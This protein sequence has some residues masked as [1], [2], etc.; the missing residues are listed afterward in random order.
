[1]FVSFLPI[2]C[3]INTS[4]DLIAWELSSTNVT[5]QHS[6]CIQWHIPLPIQQLKNFQ[7]NQEHLLL[8]NVSPS[9]ILAWDQNALHCLC[10]IHSLQHKINLNYS[11]LFKL[12]VHILTSTWNT[13][14]NCF[15]WY[16]HVKLELKTFAYLSFHQGW[17]H[18]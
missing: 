1:M 4:W 12:H 10:G 18:H 17:C 7:A 3:T 5:T 6:N 15:L 16:A 11:V 2:N 14:K 8:E 9:N 13:Y